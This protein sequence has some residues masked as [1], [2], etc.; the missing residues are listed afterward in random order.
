MWTFKFI[1]LVQ[2]ARFADQRTCF[3]EEILRLLRPWCPVY[4]VLAL[5]LVLTLT[6]VCV[7]TFSCS[8]K[9]LRPTSG[10]RKPIREEKTSMLCAAVN[11]SFSPTYGEVSLFNLKQLNLCYHS[12]SCNLN[13][14]LNFSL[15]PCWKKGP[16]CVNIFFPKI[17]KIVKLSILIMLNV[18]LF[19]FT[20]LHN[21][22]HYPF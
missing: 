1:N 2:P 9:G 5:L 10:I 3:R 8:K 15:Y 12:H 16:L 6:Y 21:Y 7:G 14:H 17:S 11:T 4:S 20:M 19:T 13:L 18:Q 22:H